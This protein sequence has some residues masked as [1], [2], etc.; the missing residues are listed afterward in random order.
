MLSIGENYP[1]ISSYSIDQNNFNKGLESLDK[2]TNVIDVV[3]DQTEKSFCTNITQL[4]G[5]DGLVIAMNKRTYDGLTQKQRDI[6]ARH[7]KFAVFPLDVIEAVVGGSA[8]CMI[9]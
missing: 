5:K 1:V 8:R 3:S 7:S 2:D 9:A 6:L 4:Y